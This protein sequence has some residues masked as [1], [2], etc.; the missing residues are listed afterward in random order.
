MKFLPRI[1]KRISLTHVRCLYSTLLLPPLSL[2][3]VNNTWCAPSTFLKC[4]F[5]QMAKA[6][7]LELHSLGEAIGSGFHDRE[8][9]GN[10][11]MADRSPL[12][13]GIKILRADVGWRAT[14][15]SAE[16]SGRMQKQDN[17]EEVKQWIRCCLVS[18]VACT[19][20]GLGRWFECWDLCSLEREK[21]L[22][23]NT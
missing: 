23:V 12:R 2:Y 5:Q 4:R 17:S 15:N 14:R 3:C 8:W 22:R 16:A 1:I 9:T 21:C 19:T 11:S 10:G 6:N 20:I 13:R 18:V 7:T